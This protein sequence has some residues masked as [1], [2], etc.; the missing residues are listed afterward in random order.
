MALGFVLFRQVVNHVRSAGFA[1]AQ[2]E[3]RRHDYEVEFVARVDVCP[4]TG[5]EVVEGVDGETGGDIGGYDVDIVVGLECGNLAAWMRGSI[6]E[7]GCGCY[8]TVNI[9][10]GSMLE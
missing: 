9:C 1:D 2:G 5:F 8:T 4:G 7:T 10:Y 3:Q 6:E